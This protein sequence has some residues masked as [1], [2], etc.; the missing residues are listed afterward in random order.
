MRRNE[1]GLND[2]GKIVNNANG[3][4]IINFGLGIVIL[5]NNN[6]NFFFCLVVCFSRTIPISIKF[7]F[8]KR[9]E[10]CLHNLLRG[11]TLKFLVELLNRATRN[12]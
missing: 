6:N 5:E 8:F 3:E 2:T 9:S 11:M 4:K 7:W 1:R 10:V 12:M